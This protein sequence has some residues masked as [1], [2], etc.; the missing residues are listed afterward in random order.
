MAKVEATLNYGAR[1]ELAGAGFD[2]ALADAVEL[3]ERARARRSSTPF[4]DQQVIAGQGTIGLE[5]AEQVPE[6]SSTLVVPVGGG[7]LASG[8]ALAL[9]ALRPE[10]ADR[11]RAGA[12]MAPLPA[13]RS[14][15][16]SPTASRSSSPAS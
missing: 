10:R 16:R 12:A 5:L 3:R 1:V 13:R 4:D 2:E 6:A 9:A 15:G 7:G 8:I 14:A 11:R